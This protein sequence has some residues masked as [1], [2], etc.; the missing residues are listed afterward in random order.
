MSLFVTVLQSAEG[1]LASAED[2]QQKK[3]VLCALVAEIEMFKLGMLQLF[4]KD[5][6]AYRHLLLEEQLASDWL[7]DVMILHLL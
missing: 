7:T 4:G 3:S 5:S 1:K 2:Y 6:N